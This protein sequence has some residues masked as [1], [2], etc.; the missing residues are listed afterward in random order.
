MKEKILVVED[1]KVIRDSIR[2]NLTLHGYEVFQAADTR[3][4]RRV[5]SRQEIDL[6][7]L[8]V[9][10]PGENGLDFLRSFRKNSDIPVLF[11]TAVDSEDVVVEGLNAGAD[12]Y[13]V[14]PFRA[15]ELLARMQAVMRR[16]G[17]PRRLVRYTSGD[18]TIDLEHTAAMV[19]GKRIDL[20]HM[21][22]Q[23]LCK[24]VEG[25]GVVITRAALADCI[26]DATG[27]AVEDNTLTVM[28]SRLRLKLGEADGIMTRRGLGYFWKNRVDEVY[29]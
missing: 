17:G 6:M 26:W 16:K 9:M 22:Y 13:I 20:S 19:D 24:I 28:L 29:E 21:E 2:D 11:L 7:L 25:K 3:E 14:K 15:M 12:D 23:I 18:L 8:D 1:N 27:R 4:A 10:L 5:V